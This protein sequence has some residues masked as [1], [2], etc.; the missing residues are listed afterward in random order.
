M[1]S[2]PGFDWIGYDGSQEGAS[3]A[4]DTSNQ[5]QKVPYLVGQNNSEVGTLHVCLALTRACC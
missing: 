1:L 4:Q 5:D 2:R 3:G